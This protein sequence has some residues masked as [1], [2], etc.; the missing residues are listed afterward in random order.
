MTAGRHALVQD[1]RPCRWRPARR[2]CRRR[3]AGAS[4]AAR[5]SPAGGCRA[6]GMRLVD[7]AAQ[8]FDEGAGNRQIRPAGVGRG[9]EQH[10]PAAATARGGDQRRAVFQHRPGL[11]FQIRFLQC[12]HL[13]FDRHLARRLD[14][15]ERTARLEGRHLLGR[16]PGQRAAEAAVA[17]AQSHGQQRILIT[18]RVGGCKAR[19]GETDQHAALVDPVRQR[20]PV[21]CG[22][23][24]ISAITIAETFWPIRAGIAVAMLASRLSRMSEKGA[25]ARGDVIERAQ[26]RLRDV[27]GLTGEKADDA[28]AEVVVEQS[29]PRRHWRSGRR[30][31]G[32]SGCAIPPAR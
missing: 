7:D 25:S 30:R 15:E 20:R 5:R 23:L 24:P 2:A 32:R 28:A 12:Q 26:Q 8:H 22:R 3:R 4:A 13:A 11:G 14:A 10:Q 21:S 6:M 1:E 9:V 27:G 19:A 31:R 29:A 16:V 17:G 18:G